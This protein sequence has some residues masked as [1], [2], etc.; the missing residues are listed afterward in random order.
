MKMKIGFIGLGI[1]GSRMAANLQKHG[2]DLVVFNRTRAKAE[3]LGKQGATIADSAA[4]VA[5]QA[6]VL[7]TMLSQPE[8]VAQS[9]SGPDGFLDQL[10]ANSIWIDC[11]TVNPSFSKKMAAGAALR[12]IRFL[13]A[14][15]SGSAPIAAAGKLVF[16]VGGEGP[17]V[18]KVRPLLLQLGTRIVHAGPTGSGSAMKLVV[19]LLLGAN[20]AAFAEALLLGE[21]LGLPQRV[22]FDALRGMPQVPPFVMSKR[23]KIENGSYEVEFPLA[24]MQKD[25]HLATVSGYETGAALPLTNSAKELYRLAM[26]HGHAH[27]D[28]SAIYAY[29]AS[30]SASATQPQPTQLQQKAA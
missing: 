10:R 29:L 19:N 14:P 22:I 26:R 13:D 28:F 5:A 3:P 4:E 7:F 25:L 23:E 11:S 30:K 17:D 2:C 6:D 1:M 16:W 18:D 12:S 27:D 24:W 20:M 15:V 21:S 9:A 8:A